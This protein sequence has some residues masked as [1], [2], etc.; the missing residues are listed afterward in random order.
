MLMRRTTV[1]ITG[2][3]TVC[4]LLVL[5]GCSRQ[6]VE[7]N[8]PVPLN[9]GD[10]RA[11]YDASIDVLR[12]QGYVIDRH[13]YRFGTITT[14]PKGSPNLLEV[15]DTQNS[16]GEQAVESTLEDLQRRV[17]V[18]LS[19]AS[20]NEASANADKTYRFMVEVLLERKQVPTRRLAGSAQRNVFSDL[21]APPQNLREHGVTGSYYEPI[22][23]DT[24]LEARLIE[25][26]N[27]RAAELEEDVA[28]DEHG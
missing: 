9:A 19:P 12:D 18:T 21:A 28:T 23:R 5:A 14:K 6:I 24:P 8:N 17:T 7:T 11:Y 22:G 15:W 13:D 26:I 2:L 4:L 16:T 10:Y 20:D 25:K 27:K 3:L 1:R